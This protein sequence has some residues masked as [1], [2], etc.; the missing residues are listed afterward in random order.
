MGWKSLG[1]DAPGK[2]RTTSLQFEVRE[3][4]DK[5]IVSFQADTEWLER[6]TEFCKE[7]GLKRSQ[8]LRYAAMK[9]MA[10]YSQSS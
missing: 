9:E 1:K 5:K 2:G 6:L 7:T 3:E 8:F 4:R 10:N